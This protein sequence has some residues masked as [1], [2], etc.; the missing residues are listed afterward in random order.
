MAGYTEQRLIPFPS[1]L[2]P[3]FFEQWSSLHLF[4]IS[5]NAF[6][7]I[8]ISSQVYGS[9]EGHFFSFESRR[10]AAIGQ[11]LSA[12]VGDRRRQSATV[13]DRRR[14][15]GDSRR[16]S[17]TGGDSRRQAATGGDRRRQAATGGDRRRVAVHVRKVKG[18]QRH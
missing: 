9:R 7:L 2:F 10:Q 8:A 12:T 4:F 16:Q 13:G 3:Y 6:S 11:R 1:F 18:R 17:A 15:F 14:Q 5:R